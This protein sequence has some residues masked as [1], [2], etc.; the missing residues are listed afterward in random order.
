M[1][2]ICLLSHRSR[3]LFKNSRKLMRI[4]FQ[5]KI[6]KRANRR[7]KHNQMQLK[8]QQMR[9]LLLTVQLLLHSGK[10][11]L[12]KLMIRL[13]IV[14]QHTAHLT[15]LPLVPLTLP[16]Q[17]TSLLRLWHLSKRRPNHVR[18]WNLARKHLINCPESSVRLNQRLKLRLRLRPRPKLRLKLLQLLLRA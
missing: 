10:H 6:H 16:V 1:N 17:K 15:L 8:G 3:I 4:C 2:M 5:L 9:L 13:S 7:Q 14:N 12:R 11:I 18:Y